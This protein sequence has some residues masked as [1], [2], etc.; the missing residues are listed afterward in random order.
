MITFDNVSKTY[1]GKNGPTTVLGPISGTIPAGGVTSIVGPNGAGKSTLLTIIGRLLEP[2]TGTVTVGG[3]DVTRT[4]SSELAR[5]LAILRQE[6]HVTARLTVRDL[7]SLG[8]FPHSRGRLTPRDVEY[9]DRSLEFLDLLPYQDRFLDQLSGGQRQRAFVAL[10]IAQDA[11]YVL[12]DEPLNNLDMRHSVEMLRTVRRAADRG[13]HTFVMVM[14]D[15]NYAAA[16]SD[17]IIA[18]RDGQIVGS[19]PV[20]EMMDGELLSDVFGTPIHIHELDGRL[21]AVQPLAV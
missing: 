10:V 19:G 17:N 4:P 8:R 15:L 12:L 14:H 3:L 18:L 16:Y 7:V 20:A 21:T 9:V 1:P 5:T 2:T 6:N 11:E 13:G